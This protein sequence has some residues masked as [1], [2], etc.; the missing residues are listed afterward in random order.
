MMQ[1]SRRAGAALAVAATALLATA[2]AWPAQA[3]TGP[4]WRIVFTRQYQASQDSGYEAALAFGQDN[5]WVFGGS[6]VG[7]NRGYPV[8]EHWNG[9]SWQAAPLPAGLSGTTVAAS[10]SSP[11]DIWAV[12]G[13]NG[14]VL[15]WNGSAWSVALKLTETSYPS[16]FTGVTAIS[17][18]DVWVFGGSLNGRTGLVGYGTWHF[19]GKTWAKVTGQGQ[20]IIQASAVSAS[21]IWAFGGPETAYDE[22]EQFNGTAWHQVSVPASAGFPYYVLAQSAD[23]VWLAGEN[24]ASSQAYATLTHWNGHA[25]TGFAVP[26]AAPSQINE[27]APDGQGGLWIEG[28]NRS[29]GQAWL[30]HRSASGAWTTTTRPAGAQ[31]ASLALIPGT[32]SLWGAGLDFVDGT[33]TATIWAYGP[34]K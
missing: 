21:D 18:T 9:T 12:S 6:S 20:N 32:A 23:S 3:A 27:M 4:G 7:A 11:S 16:Q 14:Y 22:V 30:L 10:A 5:A 17:P 19:N 29:S 8:A 1:R 26:V 13:L 34:A 15:H 31:I 28:Q 33:S 2:G 25:W 24:T